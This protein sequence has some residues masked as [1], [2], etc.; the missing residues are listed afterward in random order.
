MT[1]RLTYVSIPAQIKGFT[2]V[3]LMVAVLVL[4]IGL[5]G[6]AGLQVWGLANNHNAYLRTQATLLAQ[7]MADRMRQSQGFNPKL[8]LDPVENQKKNQEQNQANLAAYLG[9]ETNDDCATKSCT[10]AQMAGYNLAQWKAALTAHLPGGTG[11]ITQVAGPPIIYNITISW[12]ETEQVPDPNSKGTVKKFI[13]K[14][15]STSVQP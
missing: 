14:T 2:L 4:A 6:L 13:T 12:T 11:T 15:F 7:D 10:S 1:K 9:N 8:S 5:L 3:E